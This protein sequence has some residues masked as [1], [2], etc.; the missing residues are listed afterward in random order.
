MKNIF[1]YNIKSF[2][3]YIID[4]VLNIDYIYKIKIFNTFTFHFKIVKKERIENNNITNKIKQI[5]N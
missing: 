1:R 5:I 4:G 3:F 2:D